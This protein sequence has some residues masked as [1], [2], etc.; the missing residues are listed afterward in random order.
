M[1]IPVLGIDLGKNSSRSAIMSVWSATSFASWPPRRG[2]SASRCNT[3]SIRDRPVRN[4]TPHADKL[5]R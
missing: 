1:E 3:I 4:E 5:S 2:R